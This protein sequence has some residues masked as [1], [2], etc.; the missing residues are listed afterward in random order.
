MR[1]K[2]ELDPGHKNQ[3]VSRALS[4]NPSPKMQEMFFGR[5]VFC[6]VEL[7]SIHYK[8]EAM[9]LCSFSTS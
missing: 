6:G 3:R 7:F 9:K 1:L 2:R 4:Y 5:D 8:K